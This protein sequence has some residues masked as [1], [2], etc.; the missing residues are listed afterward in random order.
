[1]KIKIIDESEL[2][3]SHKIR[4]ESFKK[5]CNEKKDDTTIKSIKVIRNSQGEIVLWEVLHK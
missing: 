2:K 3:K 1:M 5:Y 4:D